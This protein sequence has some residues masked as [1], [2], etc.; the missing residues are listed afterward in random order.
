[1]ARDSL[2]PVSVKAWKT[3]PWNATYRMA[4]VIIR[5]VLKYRGKKGIY[6]R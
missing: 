1:M 3:N 4:K 5:K 6:T 2:Y